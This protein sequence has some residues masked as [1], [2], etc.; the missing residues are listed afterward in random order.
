MVKMSV[1][2]AVNSVKI[3]KIDHRKKKLLSFKI[4]SSNFKDTKIQ[5]N[6]LKL[7]YR[8]TRKVYKAY[9]QIFEPVLHKLKSKTKYRHIR[10]PWNELNDPRDL[11]P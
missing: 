11:D 7:W 9:I 1:I 5:L 2:N 4:F 10:D 8:G 6:A 3:K